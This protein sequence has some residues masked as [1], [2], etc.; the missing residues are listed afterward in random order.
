MG[1]GSNNGFSNLSP[2]FAQIKGLKKGETAR[3]EFKT[4]DP[5][6]D[7]NYIDEGHESGISGKL[8][9]VMDKSFDYEGEEVP[10]ACLI[11]EDEE[12]GEVYFLSFGISM[13]GINII[14][15]IA[16][17]ND[18]GNID[19]S[20]W[21]DKATGYNKV[22]V[23]NNGEKTEWAYAWDELKDMITYTKVKEKGKHHSQRYVHM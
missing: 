7:S 9:G 14:N 10:Q 8:A 21:N 3:I 12:E 22:F 13:I 5:D 4:K 23:R 18:I 20:V 1:R 6:D 19:I 16:G 11:L 17:C 15:S 2:V